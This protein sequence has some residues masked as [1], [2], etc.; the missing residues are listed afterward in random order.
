MLGTSLIMEKYED[1]ACGK[2]PKGDA[3]ASEEKVY[4]QNNAMEVVFVSWEGAE[5]HLQEIL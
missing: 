3:C 1:I 2:I 5:E 4:Q